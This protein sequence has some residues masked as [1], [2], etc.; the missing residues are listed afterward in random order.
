MIAPVVLRPL[1]DVRLFAPG[2]ERKVEIDVTA[3]RDGAAG[4]LDLV[5]AGRLGS[6]AR[7]AAIPARVGRRPRAVIVQRQGSFRTGHSHTHRPGPRRQPDV[8]HR[9]VVIRYPH[10]PVQLLQP[11]ARLKAVVL[12]VAIKGRRVGY[13]PG[14]GDRVA[15]ALE[16]MGYEVTRLSGADL[17]PE[18]LAGLDAVVIGVRA[19]N[20]RDDLAAHLPALFAYVEGGGTVV[21]QY[22]RPNGLRASKLAPYNLRLSDA[23]VTDENAPVTFLAPD[24][25]VLTTPNKISETDM[26]GWVQE[27]GIY[28]PSQWDE[29]F[30]PILASGRPGRD[31]AEGGPA[32]GQARPRLLRLH[33]ARLLPGATRRSSRGLPALRQFGLAR[34]MT[35]HDDDVDGPAHPAAPAVEPPDGATGL[36]WLRTW[37]GVYALVLI[38]F[39]T[40]VVLL[41]VLERSYS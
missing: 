1:S 7:V 12:D 15:E 25:P 11:P 22:N 35:L 13:I 28:F 8:E 23:R 29:H 5:G 38:C 9:R 24:H 10:I 14:A 37:P 32:G 19:Y 18:K 40:W 2:A 4:T 31:A 36:P 33:G 3:A 34:Q 6:R 26:E 39:I 20:V 30:T 21:A 27:R 17:T 16:E 41:V